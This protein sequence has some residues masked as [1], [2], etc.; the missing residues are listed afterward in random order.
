MNEPQVD[1]RPVRMLA[2]S[3]RV[4]DDIWFLGRAHRV[5]SIEDGVTLLDTP[6]RVAHGPEGWRFSLFPGAWIEVLR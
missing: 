2:E 5:T 1:P 3:I 4:G 6:F